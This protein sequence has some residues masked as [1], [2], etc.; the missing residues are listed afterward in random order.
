[1]LTHCPACRRRIYIYFT[2][3]RAVV[4]CEVTGTSVLTSVWKGHFPL[5]HGMVAKRTKISGKRNE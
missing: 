1:M 2:E 5:Q 3:Y 4:L